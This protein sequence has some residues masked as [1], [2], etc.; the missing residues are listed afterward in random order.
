M[1]RED[2]EVIKVE[3]PRWLAERFR[4]HAA[5]KYGFRKGSLSKAIADM[6]ERELKSEFS[7][8]SGTV[9]AIVGLGLQSDY[10]WDGEDLVEALRR[11]YS[12][13]NRRQHNP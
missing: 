5:E 10:E 11:K 3:L 13:P 12:L 4:R 6:I 1:G 2:V 8:A 9:D 7:L